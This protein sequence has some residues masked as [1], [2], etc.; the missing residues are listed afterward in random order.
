MHKYELAILKSLQSG[1]SKTPE[2]LMTEVSLGKDELLWAVENLSNISL[3]DIEREKELTIT[4]FPEGEVY[5]N[6]LLPEDSLLEKLKAKQKIEM[7]TLTFEK[8]KI[9]LQWCIKKNLAQVKD[10]FLVITQLGEKHKVPS[11]ES[12]FLNSLSKLSSLPKTLTS[13]EKKSVDE[14]KSRKLLEIKEKNNIISI[15]ISKKGSEFKDFSDSEHID[16]LTKEIILNKNIDSLKF[17][18]YDVSVAVPSEIISMRH[19]LRSLINDIK[20]TFSQMGFNEISGPIIEPSFWVF[21]SLFVPQDHPARDTQDTFHLSNPEFLDI[22]EKEYLKQIKKT[23]IKAWKIKWNDNEAKSAV[24]RT[25]LTSVSVRYIREFVKEFA[26]D[27][28]QLLPKKLFTVGRVF[29]NENIDYKHL[30]DFYQTDGIIIGKNLTL[31]NLFDTL[32]TFYKAFNVNIRFKP[33][34]FPFV[35]PGA[36]IFAQLGEKGEWLEIGGSGIIRREI[37]G[38]KRKDISVLAWGLGI[39]RMLLLKDKNMKSITEYYNSDL[40]WLRS[41]ELS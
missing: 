41:R 14:F 11:N 34:Y 15:K 4:F 28:N 9:A 26:K 19:P 1:K 20:V 7:K 23:N 12:I 22:D 2:Q 24:L 18:K 32:S 5:A 37:T 36:E 3:I 35:E 40:S 10:G 39:E 38:I 31:S 21:D 16:E 13:E 29:R 25:Q 8:D 17:K 33:A 6:S 30:A 27:K